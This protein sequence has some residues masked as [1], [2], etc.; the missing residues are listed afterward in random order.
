M[1][2]DAFIFRHTVKDEAATECVYGVIKFSNRHAVE[3]YAYGCV[4]QALWATFGGH[5]EKIERGTDSGIP[6]KLVRIPSNLA[7]LLS[8]SFAFKNGFL[9]CR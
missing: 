5:V 7:Q 4:W 2:I 1:A 9:T 6:E 8:D 3:D